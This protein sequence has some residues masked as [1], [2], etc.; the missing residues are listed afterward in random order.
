MKHAALILLLLSFLSSKSQTRNETRYP[1]GY[2]ANPLS[3]PM[4]LSAN[5]GELR[6]NHWHMGLDLRTDQKENYPVLAS[7]DGY[8]AHIGIR[9]SSFGRFIIINHPNGYSTLYAHLN[10]FYP[11][12]EKYVREKQTENESWAIEL[13]FSENDFKVKKGKEIGKSGNTGGSQGPHL[14]FEIRETETDRSLNPLLFGMPV[15]DDV[16][17]TLLKLALYDRS[18][19]TYDQTPKLFSLKKTDS[20][21][22]IPKLPVLKT[23]FNTLSFAIQAVDKFTGSRNANGIYTAGIF[24]DDERIAAFVLDQINYSESEYINAQIDYRFYRAG[25]GYLQHISPL[26]AKEQGV[27]HI[28]NDDGLIHLDD[29]LIHTITIQVGDANDNFASAS[30]GIQFKDNLAPKKSVRSSTN[31]FVPGYVNVFEKSDFE[32]YLPEA[33]IYDTIEPIYSR[34]NTSLPHA[35]SALHQLKDNSYPVHEEMTIKIKPTIE[36]K[37]EWRNKIVIQRNAGN[38]MLKPVWQG[39]WLTA[40]TGAFGSFIAL[41]DLTPPQINNPGKGD[42]VDLSPASR[43]VF[44]PT[45]NSGI[46]SFRAEL[47]GNWLMFTND[48]GRSWIYNFDEQCPF[49]IHHLKVRVE[50][51]VGNVTEKTWWF[52]KYPYTPPKKKVY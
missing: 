31:D 4:S 6:P 8:V 43:I 14:H 29:T 44:T 48:K 2:F 35:V 17:P 10:K 18:I 7:A 16:A 38:A 32:A 50:D 39:E 21:Y 28:Y 33:C 3:I 1:Q 23:G 47:D 12:L 11:E 25:R 40:R 51:M 24:K 42:T 19:S 13:D 9:P 5:F 52:K 20:G 41:V 36:I 27:Y 46:K 45:D 30:F 49:G 37:P 26:P 34:T 22:I 15:Q